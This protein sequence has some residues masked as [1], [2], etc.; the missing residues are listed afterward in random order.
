MVSHFITLDCRIVSQTQTRFLFC[1]R[2]AINTSYFPPWKV[3][4]VQDLVRCLLRLPESGRE[5]NDDIV[6]QRLFFFLI[7]AFV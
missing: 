1:A 5:Q 4:P 7:L 3:Q 6:A 2:K